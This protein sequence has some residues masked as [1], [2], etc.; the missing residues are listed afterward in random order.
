MHMTDT[1]TLERTDV[2]AFTDLVAQLDDGNGNPAGKAHI[3]ARDGDPRPAWQIRLDAISGGIEV[4]ALCGYR[5]VPK[6]T[7][8]DVPAC[9][10]CVAL[11]GQA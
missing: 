2:D 6:T 9:S 1:S 8:D 5:W 7:G 11:M 3:I 4:R 10:K